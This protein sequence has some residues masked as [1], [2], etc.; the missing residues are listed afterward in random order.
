MEFHKGDKV[1]FKKGYSKAGDKDVYTVIGTCRAK[2]PDSG[3]WFTA[4]M[5]S[6]KHWLY[7]RELYDFNKCFTKIEDN[8]RKP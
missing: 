8:D 5:Y 7:M 1:K 6:G 4:M 3:K 2:N